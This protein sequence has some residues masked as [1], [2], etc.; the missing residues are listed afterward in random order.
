[1]IYHIY[2]SKLLLINFTLTKKCST[3][4]AATGPAQY[5]LACM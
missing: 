3:L 5:M 1:M 4:T 2:Y